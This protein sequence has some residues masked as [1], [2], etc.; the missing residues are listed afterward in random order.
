MIHMFNKKALMLLFVALCLLIPST[1]Q[2]ADFSDNHQDGSLSGWTVE[3]GRT[4][5]ESNGSALPSN[6][7][8]NNGFLINN[9]S[10]SSNG[11]LEVR[12]SADQWNGY[13]GGVVIR[14]NSPQSFYYIAVLPGNQ[15][16]NYIA[17]CKNS[18]DATSG[19]RVAQNFPLNTTFTLK[20]EMQ[21]DRFIFYI[22]GVR[23]GEVTDDDIT[24]GKI[25][26]A[27]SNDWNR[28]TSYD[29]ISWADAGTATYTL[30]A[31]T[32]GDGTV[33]PESGVYNAGESVTVEANANSGWV[34]DHWSGDYSG[35]E[36]PATVI[37]N[38]D[39]NI[40]AHF[41]EETQY[42]TFLYI[43]EGYGS[44]QP[45]SGVYT[46][47]EP[48]TIEAT[49]EP[50]WRFDH[51]SGD[52]SGSLNPYDTVMN[53]DIYAVA[54]FVEETQYFTFTNSTVGN[55]SVQPDSGEYAEGDSI[56]IRATADPGW[57]FD[58][59]GGSLSV[60]LNPYDTVM[61]GHIH[62]IAHFVE[63]TQ[64]YRLSTAATGR[65]SIQPDSGDYE[66]GETITLQAAPAPGW[67]FDHWSGDLS[68]TQNPLEI[69]MDRN[70]YAVA[71]FVEETSV[72]NSEKISITARLFDSDG[73]PLGND[74]PVAMDFT[75]R[76]YDR[77]A[78]G[79]LMYTETF[80]DMHTQAATVYR[81]YFVVRLGEGTTGDDLQQIIRG[82]N[83][84]WAEI[85]VDDTTIPERIPLTA[86]PYSI[87][88]T[89]A[90]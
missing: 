52:L 85:V 11:V 87:Q 33:E 7:N 84:L 58:R 3:G 38:S 56:H 61:S 18:L 14:W 6:S 89:L 70:L 78:G 82:N 71:N 2:A 54:H 62:A 8:S 19:I 41:V 25:G 90:Y 74:L 39:K 60:S 9:T 4:W 51:W 20:I 27:H 57:R 1:G 69:V 53:G 86:S 88:S 48:I 17:F 36:N 31:Q 24:S 12:M 37:M 81:G 44:V 63:E 59:W 15:W 29:Q 79:N 55:G 80:L 46:R 83:N 23:R 73:N 10:P 45:D 40:T 72:P 43:V 67:R 65:G 42:F 75:V 49:A 76:L 47:G 34:F 21:G 16:S 5:S 50:G 77:Q 28:Y 30:S 22:D 13:R 66:A 35:T 32:E 26:Y 64:Y 68:G